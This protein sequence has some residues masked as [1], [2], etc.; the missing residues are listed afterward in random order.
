MRRANDDEIGIEP[1]GDPVQAPARG[2]LGG[3]DR[4]GRHAG[5]GELAFEQRLRLLVRQRFDV[6]TQAAQRERLVGMHVDGDEVSTGEVRDVLRK[7][8]RVATSREPV[9]S[10]DD[11]GE[12]VGDLGL[13]VHDPSLGIARRAAIR[14]DRAFSLRKS[15]NPSLAV[16]RTTDG[17]AK[18]STWS[19]LSGEC[20]SRTRLIEDR[21]ATVSEGWAA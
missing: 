9:D 19:Q 21:A 12:H 1:V 2:R 6:R 5:L 4:P 13:G 11:G 14:V 8:E 20:G 15:R 18:A 16:G 3:R 17:G 7:H 10:D